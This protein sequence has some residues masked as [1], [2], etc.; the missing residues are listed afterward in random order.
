MA[1]AART[2]PPVAALM[3]DLDGLKEVNR[4]LGHLAGD[5]G[6]AAVGQL[7]QSV[8]R[9]EDLVCRFGGDEF[10]LLLPGVSLEQAALVAERIRFTAQETVVAGFVVGRGCRCP[11]ASAQ[12]R[13]RSARVMSTMARSLPSGSCRDV[14]RRWGFAPARAGHTVEE[15]DARQCRHC[16]EV[17]VWEGEQW[18]TL[19]GTAYCVLSQADGQHVPSE[20]ARSDASWTYGRPQTPP[21]PSR[22]RASSPGQ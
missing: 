8:C 22:V 20:Q 13:C 10:C 15:M 21:T 14:T 5:R 6:I 18:I 2:D 16:G 12:A 19:E 9:R 11:S 4:T 3:M 17:I 1:R 7:L